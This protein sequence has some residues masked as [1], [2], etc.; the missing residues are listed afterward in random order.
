MKDQSQPVNPQSLPLFSRAF[1]QLLKCSRQKSISSS[2]TLQQPCSACQ[3]ALCE[4]LCLCEQAEWIFQF[5]LLFFIFFLSTLKGSFT[6][7]L[8]SRTFLHNGAFLQAKI[9]VSGGS[10]AA[11]HPAGSHHAL[12]PYPEGERSSLPRLLCRSVSWSAQDFYVHSPHLQWEQWVRRKIS[13]GSYLGR[14]SPV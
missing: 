4:S 9:R 1:L 10:G 13:F 5:T 11:N 14:K 2:R 3:D 6:V 12:L 8:Q 7:S